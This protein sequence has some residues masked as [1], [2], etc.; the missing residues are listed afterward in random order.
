ME[1]ACDLVANSPQSL[2]MSRELLG[3]M[4]ALGAELDRFDEILPDID[5]TLADVGDGWRRA[6]G[7]STGPWEAR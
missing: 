5:A 1:A 4:C 3:R 6:W 7:P 2:A